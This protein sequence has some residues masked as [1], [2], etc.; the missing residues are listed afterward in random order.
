MYGSHRGHRRTRWQ[1]L[2]TCGARF[3]HKVNM[4]TPLEIQ[5]AVNVQQRFNAT[6]KHAI[7]ASKRTIELVRM[8]QIA[9]LEADVAGTLRQFGVHSLLIPHFARR[10]VEKEVE[11]LNPA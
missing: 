5:H 1:G 9:A 8:G 3:Q 6:F 4:V 11:R 7:D 2:K 10:I